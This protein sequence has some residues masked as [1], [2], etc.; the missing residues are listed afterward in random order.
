MRSPDTDAWADQMQIELL[1]Q[2]GPEKRLKIALEL[3][4]MV[5]NMAR[6]AVDRYYPHETQD[7]RDLRFLTQ[8]YGRELAE[9]FIA[10]R[11]KVLGPRNETLAK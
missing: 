5:W 7:Q 3:S 10:H 2:A 6:S 4:A 1:R 11:Q 9:K 8:C